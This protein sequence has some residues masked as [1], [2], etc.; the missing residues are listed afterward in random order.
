MDE[1]GECDC[2]QERW[3]C[4][5]RISA[6]GTCS[7]GFLLPSYFMIPSG[8]H[9]FNAHTGSSL[10]ILTS[11]ISS[12][13]QGFG[14]TILLM[15]DVRDMSPEPHIFWGK[16]DVF[17]FVFLSRLLTLCRSNLELNFADIGVRV[18]GA[19]CGYSFERGFKVQLAQGQLWCVSVRSYLSTLPTIWLPVSS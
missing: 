18:K 1:R 19:I 8:S 9:Y 10:T 12:N 2:S 7:R 16:S 14:S 15:G 4:G 3:P 5:E 6:D 13:V 11:S 17:R